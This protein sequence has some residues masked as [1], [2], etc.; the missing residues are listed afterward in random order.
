MRSFSG[1]DNGYITIHPEL[2]SS[3]SYIPPVYITSVRINNS[4]TSVDEGLRDGHY[5]CG[6]VHR[7][8]HTRALRKL[9]EV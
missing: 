4:E 3:D 7:Q 8:A 1:G 9:I 6:F 5:A 2:S